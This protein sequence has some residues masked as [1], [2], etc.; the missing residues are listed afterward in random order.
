MLSKVHKALDLVPSSIKTKKGEK[1]KLKQLISINALP[2]QILPNVTSF[3]TGRIRK[4]KLLCEISIFCTYTGEGH[5]V[6]AEWVKVLADRMDSLSL[7]SWFHLAK[8][9]T[10]SHQVVL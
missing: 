4:E 7:I 9:R 10:A 3:I 1:K 2:N 8:G 5:A 6:L